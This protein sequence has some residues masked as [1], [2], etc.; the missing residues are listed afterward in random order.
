MANF[1]D[2]SNDLKELVE[3]YE[4]DN[5]MLK[6]EQ[7]PENNIVKIFGEKITALARA[8]NGLSDVTELAYTT[9]EHHPYWNILYNSAEIAQSILEKWNEKL[10][11]KEIDD[12]E[13][14]LKEINQTLEKI[15]NSS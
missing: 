12:I 8:K 3:K 2:F 4:K 9:A 13:W 10:S 7:D 15:K 11:K 5:T 14:A 1:E 6:I